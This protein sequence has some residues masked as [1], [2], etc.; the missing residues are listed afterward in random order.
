MGHADRAEASPE[1]R[2]DHERFAP[3]G[4]PRLSEVATRIVAVHLLKASAEGY[5]L[6]EG[7]LSHMDR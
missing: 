7:A 2:A 6:D 3:Q 4:C 1:R 5:V